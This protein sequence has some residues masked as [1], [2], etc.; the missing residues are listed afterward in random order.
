MLAEPVEAPPVELRRRELKEQLPTILDHAAVSLRHP[1]QRKPFRLA[2]AAVA[3]FRRA[4]DRLDF[5]EVHTPKVVA[6]ATEGG[7]NVF[8]VDWYGRDAFLAQSP[9]FYKQMLVGVFE[10]VYETGRSSAPSRTRRSA[11]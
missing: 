9:Q 7:A 6:A 11:I 1:G 5:T 2:A 4:L 3:G 8:R 10:R